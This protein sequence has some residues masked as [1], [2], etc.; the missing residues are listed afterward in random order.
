MR[1]LLGTLIVIVALTTAP[2][3]A[4]A[5][6]SFIFGMVV[7]SA[8]SSSGDTTVANQGA[9]NIMYVMPRVAERVTDPLGVRSAASPCYLYSEE[10]P[11]GWGWTRVYHPYSLREFFAKTV[12]N[13]DK[14]TILQA[15]RT[16]AATETGCVRMIFAFIENDKIRPLESLPRLTH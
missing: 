8:L 12:E 9:M 7:G 5:Q 13:P 15:V 2:L 11:D 14:Y 10:K 4:H 6:A 3:A 1:K 16:T